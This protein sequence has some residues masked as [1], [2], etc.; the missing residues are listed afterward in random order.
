MRLRA[1]S[2]LATASLFSLVQ[3]TAHAAEAA[4]PAPD[5][6]AGVDTAQ[7]DI[8]V[9]AQ[10]REQKLKDVPLTVS[11]VTQDKLSQ[12]G[13][14]ELGEMAAY[15]PGLQIQKQSA[16]NPGFVIRGITSDSGSAQAGSRV[17]VYY[18]GVDISRARGAWQ[19]LFDM[20]RVEVVKGRRPRCLARPPKWA[21]SR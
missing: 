5:A 3:G 20:E 4:A 15:V 16:N 11:V 7:S 19:D 13:V 21:R 17:S 18:N 8:V 9:T 14:S 1:V 6:S 10:K 12:L 2:L